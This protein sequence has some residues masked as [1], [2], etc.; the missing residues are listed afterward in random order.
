MQNVITVCLLVIVTL[1]SVL[2]PAVA[3]QNQDVLEQ[4]TAKIEQEKDN[5]K[6]SRLYIYRARNLLQTG[7]LEE[8][9]SDLD[10]AAELDPERGIVFLERSK[11]LLS[12]KK[13]KKARL[14][15]LAAKEKT[16]A[17]RREAD[18]LI[19]AVDKEISMLDENQPVLSIAY[20][21]DVK[22]KEKSR[23]DVVR[24]LEQCESGHWVKQVSDD[25]SVIILED[26]SEWSVDDQQQADAVSWKSG[27]FV[28]A[29]IE[30]NALLNMSNPKMPRRVNITR[31][32]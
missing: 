9:L 23:L 7:S 25:G 5:A 12:M 21:D 31:Q 4:L 2:T 24:E 11:V 14:D 1:L 3:R 8:V 10:K 13:L 26:D 6:K 19:N 27:D 30:L 32:E 22:N 17:L 18:Q 16:P 28:S 29:C 20:L 15:A